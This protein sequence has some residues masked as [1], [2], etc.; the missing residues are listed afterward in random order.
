MNARMLFGVVCLAASPL[1]TGAE[2]NH[3]APPCEGAV[4]CEENQFRSCVNLCVERGQIGDP[5]VLNPCDAG[6]GSTV[7]ANGLTCEAGTCAA[8][9]ALALQRCDPTR[10][11]GSAGYCASGTFCASIA[12]CE[13]V[14][15]PSWVPGAPAG[16]CIPPVGE[17]AACTGNFTDLTLG[18]PG[19]RPCAPGL[20]CQEV[21]WSASPVCQRPC[22]ADSECSCERGCVDG[23]CEVCF[24]PRVECDPSGPGCCRDGA[25]C[26]TTYIPVVDGD[27]IERQTCCVAE[28]ESCSSS[29]DCCPNARCSGGACKSCGLFPGAAPGPAGCCP[30]L[31][32]RTRMS[33]EPVCGLPCP[34]ADAGDICRTDGICGGE[35]RYTCHPILGDVCPEEEEVI[36]YED[37][38]DPDWTLHCGMEVSGRLE[39]DGEG[40]VVCYVPPTSVCTAPGDHGGCG[41]TVYPTGADVPIGSFDC[42]DAN[43][44][45]CPPGSYCHPVRMSSS[46]LGSG[47]VSCAEPT[48]P[49]CWEPG[50]GGGCSRYPMPM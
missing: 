36:L 12:G 21:S 49:T 16:L 1:L 18:E 10:P 42:G 26:R 7:C 5:C 32:L 48:Q 2:C 39:C 47:C 24:E 41:A 20:E 4:D 45:L 31:T 28:G 3:A 30:G 43:D 40:G 33:G 50:E 34:R 35:Q 17:G 37:C 38:T 8:T 25:E 19:C 46:L 22:A 14:E 23:L 13:N 44:D 9:P 29:E 11:P 27:P 6:A 15:Q